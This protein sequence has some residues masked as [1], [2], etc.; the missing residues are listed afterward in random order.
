MRKPETLRGRWALG[1]LLVVALASCAL[2]AAGAAA[3]SGRRS[4]PS[5][6]PPTPTPAATPE[7]ES[8]E[9][10]SESRPRP[11]AED[12]KDSAV[13]S[14]VVMESDD[15]VFGADS[16]TRRDVTESFARR[17]GQ[18][19]SVS[20][21]NGGRGNRSDAHRRAK[22]ET[23]AWVVLVSLE[24]AS[25][26]GDVVRRRPGQEENRLLV[27]RTAVFEPK[28]GTLKH[29]DTVYQRPVRESVGI[30]GVRIPVPT[31]TRTISRYPSQLELEQAAR[32][33]ADRLLS[34]FHVAP[35]S[36]YP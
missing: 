32:D 29:S 6:P 26:A 5:Y 11:R 27:V 8:G 31:G 16:M 15:Q 14:F 22:S 20:V 28:T 30:G 9:S 24:E 12:A 35:P 4:R 19:P 23:T 34:R 1:A 18:A 36:D 21:A 13:A 7:A 33:A 2:W 10:E 3:Q 25:G 17:L